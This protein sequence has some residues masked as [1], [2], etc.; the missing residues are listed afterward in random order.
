MRKRLASS[1]DKNVDKIPREEARMKDLGA[2]DSRIVSHRKINSDNVSNFF[3]KV[4]I[5]N[6]NEVL[7]KSIETCDTVV[8]SDFL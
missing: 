4:Q 2:F 5:I 3:Y 6:K 1:E 8:C 7:L